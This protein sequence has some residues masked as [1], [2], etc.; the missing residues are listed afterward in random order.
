MALSLHPQVTKQQEHCEFESRWLLRFSVPKDE[1]KRKRGRGWPILK[2]L[3]VSLRNGNGKEA[4]LVGREVKDDVEELRLVDDL[5]DFRAVL[6]GVDLA[7]L[8]VLAHR[9]VGSVTNL[10]VRM[11]FS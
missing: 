3:G 5:H 8:H 11:S 9:L 10:P 7:S 1:N 2:K 4:N 6:Q